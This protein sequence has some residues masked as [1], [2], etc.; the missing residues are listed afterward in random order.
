M[1][2]E[3]LG[4]RR[5]QPRRRPARAAV[6]RRHH[7]PQVTNPCA[8]TAEPASHDE[9]ALPHCGGVLPP[10]GRL[11]RLGGRH[12]RPPLL[13]GCRQLHPQQPR[14]SSGVVSPE[15]AQ[16]AGREELATE[17][18]QRGAAQPGGRVAPGAARR[19][20]RGME[21]RP[22]HQPLDSREKPKT[23]GG[24][25][26]LERVGSFAP[27]RLKRTTVIHTVTLNKVCGRWM[28]YR[29]RIYKAARGTRL[30][31]SQNEQAPHR[32]LTLDKV[33]ALGIQFSK[34][35]SQTAWL[36]V[37]CGRWHCAIAARWTAASIPRE[38]DRGKVQPPS[39]GAAG[40]ERQT[41]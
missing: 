17:E 36:C 39:K 10:W 4:P 33:H 20:L 32:H 3:H 37:P 31:R 8:A 28:Y 27:K 9:L 16:R 23:R 2:R 19:V 26:R 21:L 30:S 15:R 6:G 5:L 29:V 18:Q 38:A 11:G 12:A 41:H 35:P 24:H 7:A 22:A 14:A 1:A 25:P 13:R 40:R 34:S